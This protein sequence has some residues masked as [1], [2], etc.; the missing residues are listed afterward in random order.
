MGVGKVPITSAFPF[1]RD[2]SE[3]A[4]RAM[5]QE[6]LREGINIHPTSDL[7]NGSHKHKHLLVPTVQIPH[8]L[9]A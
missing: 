4:G 1:R 7:C 8:P 6:G 5:R 3:L 9:T 2:S